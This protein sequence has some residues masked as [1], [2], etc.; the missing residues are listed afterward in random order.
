MVAYF[1]P[2]GILFREGSA[3]VRMRFIGANPEPRMEGA[4]RLQAEVNYLIGPE[5]E[6]RIGIPSYT[7]V[8]YRELYPG[9]D[10]L[11]GGEGRNL[12]SVFVV[13]PEA[14]PA[15]IHVRY[16]GAGELRLEDDGTLVIP[17][18]GRELRDEAPVIYQEG[19]SGRVAVEGRFVLEGDGIVGFSIGSYDRSLPLVIDPVLSYSTLLGGSNSDAAMALA[20]DSTGIYVA[21]YTASRD[22]PTA[23]A[24][25][26]LNGGSNDIFV[27]KLNSA[28]TSLFFAT[29]IGG[30]S[31]DRANAM[32][33]DSTGAVYLTGFTTS[34]NFPVKNA[35][36]AASRGGKDAFVL[37]LNPAGNALVYSTYLGGGSSD[38]GYGIALDA[39]GNVYVTGDTTSTN[40]PASALQL[41]SGGGQDAF[42]AKLNPSGSAL[43]YSTYLGGNSDEHASSIAV[44]STGNAYITGSTYSTNFPTV[45]AAQPTLGGGQDAFVAKLAASGSSLLFSTY[46]GGTGGAVGFPESGQAIALDGSGNVYVT[47]V[48][49]STDLPVLHALQTAMHGSTDAFVAKW[50]SSGVLQYSTWLGGMGQETGNAIR[51]DSSGNAYVAGQTYSTDLAVVNAIQSANG[52]GYDAF[53]AELAPTGDS[54]LMLSYLG[55]NGSDAATSI[56][57]DGTGA[58]YLAGWTLSTNF[59]VVNGYQA[60]NAGNYGAFVMKILQSAPGNP[61]TVSVTPSSGSGTTQSFAFLVSDPGGYTALRSVQL[62]IGNSLATANTCY[63]FYYRATNA[64]YLTNDP[65]TAWQAPVTLGQSGTLQNS[66]CSIDALSSSASGS[67]TNLTLN[68]KLTFSGSFAGSR[69]VY[70]EAYD[71]VGDSGWFQRGTW[72]VPAGTPQAVSVSPSSG[73]GSTQVFTFTYSDPRG[74]T[75]I[76]STQTLIGS[77]LFASGSCYLFFNRYLNT[78]YLF[79]DAGTAWSSPVT[80]GQAGT[81]QNGQCALNA[82]ASSVTGVGNTLTLNLSLTFK[83]SYAGSKNVYMEVYDGAS[84]SGWVQN[85]V[86]TIPGA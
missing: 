4:Q 3:S 33:V 53:L 5:S 59:P 8:A 79:N 55:G 41:A 30:S 32:A 77:S 60:T 12:K 74:Y 62:L 75:A 83:T 84:D 25:Q 42:V 47:G 66:Q 82:A 48:T 18:D 6:W 27:A 61:Q 52:G 17:L 73:S 80:L 58:I 63:L 31:D 35:I 11:F 28:G 76:G 72:T 46:F 78:I 36:Q 81:L 56:A 65:A 44:D 10:M 49:A 70:M 51:V 26:S 43:V 37:K 15:T 9:I 34:T 20:V 14:D 21:G 23:T 69:N 16:E 64:L 67:G 7:G 1:S 19:A 86:W 50:S 2:S 57:L 68:L 13:A 45:S 38:C 71:G 85:G 24:E 54:L 39:N 22:F 40:F 29:Y